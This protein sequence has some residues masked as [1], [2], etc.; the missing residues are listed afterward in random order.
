MIDHYTT[1]AVAK[2]KPETKIV[3]ML[4]VLVFYRV[5]NLLIEKVISDFTM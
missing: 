2:L 3:R 5:M 1:L 4:S